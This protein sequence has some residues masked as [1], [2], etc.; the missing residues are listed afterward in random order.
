MKAKLWAAPALAAVAAG[1]IF[2]LFVRQS[3]DAA[4]TA[5]FNTI[6]SDYRRIIVLMDGAESL[7]ATTHAK[8]AAAGRLLF[9]HKLHALDEVSRKLEGNRGG[10]RQLDRYLTSNKDLHNADKL[11]FLDL[12]EGLDHPGERGGP[13]KA[14]HDNL[15]SIQ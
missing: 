3:D 2:F 10:I 9:S 6:T 15:L 5:G 1:A 8:A 11:A 7:D 14:L 13:L 12:V 4:L